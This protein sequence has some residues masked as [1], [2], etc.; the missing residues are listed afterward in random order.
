LSTAAFA[1]GPVE[2]LA[3]LQR[4]GLEGLLVPPALEQFATAG[5]AQ[6]LTNPARSARSSSLGLLRY[7]RTPKGLV[8]IVLVILAAIA[9][10]GEGVRLVAP[11]LA[12]ATGAAM[13]IDAPILRFRKRSGSSDGALIT[14]LII[15]HDPQSA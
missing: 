15:A 5:W 14:G 6:C 11:G 9:S 12:G 13:L 10:A 3:L 8:L 1:L 2:G 7:A 4:H